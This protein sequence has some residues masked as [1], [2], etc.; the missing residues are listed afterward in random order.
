[1]PNTGGIQKPRVAREF[2]QRAL[3]PQSGANLQPGLT[4]EYRNRENRPKQGV[5]ENFNILPNQRAELKVK[6]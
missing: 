6:K 5:A 4:T 2:F 1:M 3:E